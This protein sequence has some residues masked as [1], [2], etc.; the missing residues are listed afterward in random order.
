VGAT[1][2][3]G[4]IVTFKTVVTTVMTV[5]RVT[6]VTNFQVLRNTPREQEEHIAYTSYSE[7]YY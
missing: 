2:A 1:L 3:P 4:N 6:V 7:Q 5:I